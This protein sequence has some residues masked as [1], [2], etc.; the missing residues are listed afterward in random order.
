MNFQDLLQDETLS[1]YKGQNLMTF[2]IKHNLDHI[3]P[4]VSYENNDTVL[5]PA[6]RLCSRELFF[7]DMDFCGP[8]DSKYY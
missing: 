2:D 8:K 3:S 1:N 7:S 6:S 5:T 4:M